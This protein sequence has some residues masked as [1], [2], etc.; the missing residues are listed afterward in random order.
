MAQELLAVIDILIRPRAHVQH[1]IVFASL[2]LIQGWAGYPEN[3]ITKLLARGMLQRKC[4]IVQR[5]DFYG[6]RTNY[7]MDRTGHLSRVS[8]LL[9]MC[10]HFSGQKISLVFKV[11]S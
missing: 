2:L 1:D 3:G 9:V 10:Q 11:C 8:T 4:L 6:N 7:A 5:R